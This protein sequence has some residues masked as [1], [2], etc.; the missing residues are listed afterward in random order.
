MATHD[1]HLRYELSKFP[2]VDA[3]SLTQ[4]PFDGG[5]EFDVACPRCS[6]TFTRVHYP[7]GHYRPWFSSSRPPETP[8]T[9]SVACT[10]GPAHPERPESVQGCGATWEIVP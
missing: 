6:A 4:R 7:R 3:A 8:K 2:A 9:I 1:P 10:C 5:I